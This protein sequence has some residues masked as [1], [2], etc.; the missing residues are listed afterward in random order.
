MVNGLPGA[1]KSTLA[2]ALALRWG[3]TRYSKDDLKDALADT[4]SQE[5]DPAWLSR[6]ADGLLWYLASRRQRVV[7]ETWFGGSDKSPNVLD[8]LMR[9]GIPTSRVV[10]VWCDVPM[11]V[12]RDRFLARARKDTSRHRRHL[13]AG[14]DPA[15]WDEIADAEPLG[16]SRVVRVD[17]TMPLSDAEVQGVHEAALLTQMPQ[18]RDAIPPESGPLRTAFGPN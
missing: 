6:E 10:E 17:T 15:W 7:V 4:C 14:A 12:A 18:R 11:R 2:N 5:P 8:R 16:L 3:A 13:Q 9:C 1:G